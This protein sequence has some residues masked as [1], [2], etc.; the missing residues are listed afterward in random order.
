MGEKKIFPVYFYLYDFICCFFSFLYF[1]LC[2]LSKLSSAA[3]LLEDVNVFEFFIYSRIIVTIRRKDVNLCTI[4]SRKNPN[5]VANLNDFYFSPLFCSIFPKMFVL[6]F[7]FGIKSF[8]RM[9][10]IS[11]IRFRVGLGV[12][13]RIRIALL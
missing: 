6:Y 8:R 2:S 7:E 4:Y 12:D 5:H 3:V 1:L 10:R 13:W 9:K 11:V